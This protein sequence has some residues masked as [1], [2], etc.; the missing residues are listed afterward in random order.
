MTSDD[1]VSTARRQPIVPFLR[2]GSG[3]EQADSLVGWKCGACGALYLSRRVACARC[4]VEGG[5][6]EVA[7]SPRGKL[8]VYTIV[9]QSAP[10]VPVPFVSAIVDLEDGIAVR[11]TLIDVEP[12]PAK[13]RFDMPVEMVTRTVRQ[14]KEGNDVVAFFFRPAGQGGGR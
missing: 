4:S 7:L 3:A 6:L 2:L 9:H 13:L 11:C 10:G 8:Y 12:E 5:F 14:D 1:A